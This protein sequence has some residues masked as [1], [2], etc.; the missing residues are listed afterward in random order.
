MPAFAFTRQPDALPWFGTKRGAPLLEAEQALIAQAL[1]SRAPQPWL[2]LSAA[3]GESTPMT[4]LPR[5]LRLHATGA[6]PSLTGSV[7]CGLPLPLPTEAIGS[8]VVQHLLDAGQ[9]DDLLEECARV[10][11]PG[12][13]LW[14]F[15]VNP[16][17][18]YRL[19]W[20]RAG[21]QP[22]DATGWRLRLREVGLQPLG[23]AR[24]L[25]PV[26]RTAR[27]QASRWP[28]Q[29]R[30]VCVLQAEKRVAGLI[31]PAPATARTWR[32]AAPA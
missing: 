14:L 12:G 8:I 5:G 6:A 2:W 30:A 26:W 16:F 15:T 19:R 9:G 22:L 31:P 13:R 23:D 3:A 17:S 32:A 24:Y 28:P 21:L 20:R 27:P 18:P 29:L 4:P 11:E 7:R 10:L 25:G 1:A